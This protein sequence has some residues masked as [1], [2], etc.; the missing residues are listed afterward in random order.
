ME[1]REVFPR[2]LPIVLADGK[3]YRLSA[4]RISELVL[5]EEHFNAPFLTVLAG[6]G[7]NWGSA[8]DGGFMLHTLLR[9]EHSELTYE[10]ACDLVQYPCDFSRVVAAVNEVMGLGSPTAD[11]SE[12]AEKNSVSRDSSSA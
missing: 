10:Q 3:E 2:S 6:G 4:P 1:L 9:K 5:I 12:V 7:I 11:Q 8:R